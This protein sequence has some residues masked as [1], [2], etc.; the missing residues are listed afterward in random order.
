MKSRGMT[1]DS[2]KYFKQDDLFWK[3]VKS[4]HPTEEN[5]SSMTDKMTY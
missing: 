2:K 3:W 4:F 1:P 5:K